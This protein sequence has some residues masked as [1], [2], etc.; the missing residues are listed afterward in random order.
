MELGNSF[1]P[2][3]ELQF[4]LQAVS[5]LETISLCGTR[6]NHAGLPDFR[7]QQ[8]VLIRC[9]VV[10]MG[11]D[12]GTPARTRGIERPEIVAAKPSVTT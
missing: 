10:H 5:S 2:G 4:A 8:F 1:V 9:Q 6:M 12:G 3:P 11:G 7:R